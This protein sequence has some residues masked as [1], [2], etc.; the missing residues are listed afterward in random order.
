MVSKPRQ[1]LLVAEGERADLPAE[2]AARAAK[3]MGSL[4]LQLLRMEPARDRGEQ[5][6]GGSDDPRS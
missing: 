4:V 2:V 3:V 5:E 1:L 6:K